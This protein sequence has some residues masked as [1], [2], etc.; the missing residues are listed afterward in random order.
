[1]GYAVIGAQASG[2]VMSAIGAA[3]QVAGQKASLNYQADVANMNARLAEMQAE[4]VLL[5]GQRRAG[6]VLMKGA[7]VKASQKTAMAANGIALD[8]DTAARNIASTEIMRQT[9]ALTIDQEATQQAANARTQRVNYENEARFKSMTADALS[10]N[11]AMF[12]SLL[13]SAGSVGTNWYQL[14]KSGAIS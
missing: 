4:S 12:T 6:R 14:K 9:D 11:M 2:A 8:S 3:S 7:Q 10:P 1:M 13:G 5:T